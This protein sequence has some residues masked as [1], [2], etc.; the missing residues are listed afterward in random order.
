MDLSRVKVILTAKIAGV[1]SVKSLTSKPVNIKLDYTHK[2][3]P[4]ISYTEYNPDVRELEL[5]NSMFVL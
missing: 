3:D 1:L 4:H 2:N 5:E